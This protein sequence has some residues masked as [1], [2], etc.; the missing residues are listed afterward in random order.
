MKY[1][2]LSE[3][4]KRIWDQVY[5]IKYAKYEDAYYAMGDADQAII[6]LRREKKQRR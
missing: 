3:S 1:E 2:D 5:A 6:D 4:E